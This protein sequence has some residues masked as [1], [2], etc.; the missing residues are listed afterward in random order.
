MQ[1]LAQFGNATSGVLTSDS[2]VNAQKFPI[3]ADKSKWHCN[4][5]PFDDFPDP[6]YLSINNF[7]P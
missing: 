5:E 6:Y 7:L 3:T 1:E 2:P 4:L